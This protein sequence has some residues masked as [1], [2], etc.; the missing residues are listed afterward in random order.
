[1]DGDSYLLEL[2]RYIHLNPVRARL[3]KNLK[4]SRWSSHQAYLGKERLPWLTTEWVLSQFG[5]QMQIARRRYQEFISEGAQEGHREEFHQGTVDTRVLGDDHFVE[6]I[7]SKCEPRRVQVISIGK[8]IQMV[9]REYGVEEKT[10]K[11]VAQKRDLSEA[12]AVVGWLVMEWGCGTLTEAGRQ[13]NRDV[14]TM[15]SAVKRLLD[16][17]IQ[18]P[19]LRKRL[20]R[21]KSILK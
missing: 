2:T 20:E 17:F 18:E 7:L 11:T 8:V 13:L 4:D 15:S 21:L 1:M 10:L 12:R 19:S 3:V 5:K 9:S 16:R 6:R 14:S